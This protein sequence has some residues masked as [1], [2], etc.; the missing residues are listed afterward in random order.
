MIFTVFELHIC[1]GR[2]RFC[3]TATQTNGQMTRRSFPP[4]NYGEHWGRRP[5]CP[6][7]PFC[8][9]QQRRS[10]PAKNKSGK[11]AALP[12]LQI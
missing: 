4:R 7:K 10:P 2:E 1:C 5:F 12:D 9:P 6:Q 11:A 3:C 8:L